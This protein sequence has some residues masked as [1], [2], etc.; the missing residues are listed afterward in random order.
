[1]PAGGCPRLERQV[2]P[3]DRRA[4]HGQPSSVMDVSC[5][6][7]RAFPLDQRAFLSACQASR[8]A[9]LRV[10]AHPP[11]VVV[12]APLRLRASVQSCGPRPPAFARIRPELWSSSPC[13]S[14]HPSSVSVCCPPRFRSSTERFYPVIRAVSPV[15]RAFRSGAP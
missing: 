5:H 7:S 8:T 15:G 9:A 3:R 1:V 4:G 12:L 13:V 6:A 10:L 2:R 11:S 14:A